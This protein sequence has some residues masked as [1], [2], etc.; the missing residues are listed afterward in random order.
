MHNKITLY[1]LTIF[2]LIFFNLSK[3]ASFSQPD[4]VQSFANDVKK[5]H[6]Q[7]S[8]RYSI[9]CDK[10][11]F[12]LKII[13]FILQ[14]NQLILQVRKKVLF[15]ANKRK[16]KQILT[17]DENRFL[18]FQLNKY[19]VSSIN[20]LLERVDIIPP[21]LGLAQS[22]QETCWG[23][24]IN[25]QKRNAFFG[26]RKKNR[27]WPF[28]SMKECVIAYINNF[29]NH[30]GYK[31]FR[32]LRKQ[33]REQKKCIYGSLL[34]NRLQSYCPFATYSNTIKYIINRYELGVFDE[35]FNAKFQ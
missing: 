5:L 29:N 18:N 19:K 13:W 7:W 35:F 33:L 9:S 3:G 28:A 24:S 14:E 6:S 12:S 26:M 27:C 4:I 30:P 22:I 16:I 11:N 23:K 2:L 8:N 17:P 34:A 20:A 15:I 1:C 31:N 21:S 25:A 10:K 32:N